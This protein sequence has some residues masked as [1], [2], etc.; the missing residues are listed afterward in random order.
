M[1]TRA[2]FTKF[3]VNYPPPNNIRVKYDYSKVDSVEKSQLSKGKNFINL[4]DVNLCIKRH[5]RKDLAPKF[6]FI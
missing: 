1:R 3:F 5:Q 2:L 4:N 6:D